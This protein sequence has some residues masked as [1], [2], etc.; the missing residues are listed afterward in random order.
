M[1]RD[2]EELMRE[3]RAAKR[4]A[5]SSRKDDARAQSF[6]VI[7]FMTGAPVEDDGRGDVIDQ[8][9]NSVNRFGGNVI[10]L[11]SRR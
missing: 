2:L 4:S 10:E 1:T 9:C 7:D 11:R 6:I 8:N 5:N 3:A